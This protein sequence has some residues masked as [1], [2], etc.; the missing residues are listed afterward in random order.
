MPFID[1]PTFGKLLASGLVIDLVAAVVAA[2]VVY[3]KTSKSS[4]MVVVVGCR[5]AGLSH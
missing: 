1:F 4:N 3:Q 5:L 2:I